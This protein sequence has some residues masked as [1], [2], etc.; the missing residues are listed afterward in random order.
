M[1]LELGPISGCSGL[2][3]GGAEVAAMSCTCAF[4]PKRAC[5]E[6]ERELGVGIFDDGDDVVYDDDGG[7]RGIRISVLVSNTAE[8]RRGLEALRAG[9]KDGWIVFANL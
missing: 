8:T 6:Y 3:L 2:L 7:C 4:G 1:H 9:G 5:R